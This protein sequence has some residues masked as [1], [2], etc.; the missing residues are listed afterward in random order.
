M[1]NIKRK[2]LVLSGKGGEKMAA[3]F[4]VPFLGSIPIE[5]A[6]V[7][8]CDS[9]RPFINSDNQGPTAQ[10]LRAAF[11]PLLQRYEQIQKDKEVTV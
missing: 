6:M 8:A 2:F 10:A 11:E 4:N 3:E 9:D 5:S 7:L 1:Q